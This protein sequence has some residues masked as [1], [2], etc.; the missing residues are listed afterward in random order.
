[1]SLLICEPPLRP[2]PPP[3]LSTLPLPERA[4][5]AHPDNPYLQTEWMRAVRVVRST[6]GGW[7]A[8]LGRRP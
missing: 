6:K 3:I 2:E 1:M 4:A 7:V 5:L 8:D